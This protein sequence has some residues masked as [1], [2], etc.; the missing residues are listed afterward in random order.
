MV[1]AL[2]GTATCRGQDVALSLSSGSASPG[3]TVTL[4]ISLTA[5]TSLPASLE[6]TLSY[7]TV[8]F[9]SLTI[10]AGPVATGAN[11][12]VTCATSA[13]ISRCIVSGLNDATIP[14]GV[15]ATIS[16]T[17]S[18]STTDTS[19]QVQFMSDM[20]SGTGA[21]T[22][23]I[24]SS[25]GVV[26][27]VPVAALNGFSCTP[28]TVSPSTGSTCT[29]ALTRAPGS[30]GATIDL[31]SSPADVTIPST[32][33][34][35]QGSTS[36][37]F[38]VG[39]RSV[40][41]ATTVTLGASYSS[42]SETFGLTVDPALASLKS[43][44]VS[45]ASIV[46]GQSGTGTVTLASAAPSGGAV[47]SLSSPNAAVS[48]PAS[49]TVPQGSTSA[50]FSVTTGTVTTS[51]SVTLTASYSGVTATFGITVNPVA[52][53][54][55]S[56]SVS[57]STIVSGQSGKGTVTLTSAAPSGGAVVSLS[58]T[59]AAASVPVSLTVPQGA[60]SVT[61]NVTTGTVGTATSITLTAS[62]DS[63]NKTAGITVNP[64]LAALSSLSVS[65]ST[66]VSG[67]PGTGTVTL[68]AAAPSGG[69]VVSLL[70]STKNAAVSVPASVTIAQG[71]TSA[72]FS[73]IAGTVTTSTSVTLSASYSGV[74][75][76]FALTVN[77]VAASLSSL[78][79]SPST[80]VSG[81]PGT[82]TVTLTAAA[83][84]GGAV[85]SLLLSAKNAP[86]SVPASVTIAQG[87]TSATFSVIAG[88]VTTST[89]VTLS[90]SYSG[91]TSTFALTVNPVAA[92]LSSLSVS[93]S[94]IVGGQSGTGTV[95]LTA[96]APAGGAVV[97]LSSP[98]AAA[99]VP[100]TVTV[101]QGSTLV[102]F[103][104]TAGTVTASTSITLTASYSGVAATFGVTVNPGAAVLTSIS[105]S[106]STIV[107]GQSGTGTV[108]ITSAAPSGGAL[109][110]LSSSNSSAAS[111]PASV[112]VA[113]G[114]I[115][116][117]FSVTT[118]IVNAAT[119]VT[120]TATYSGVSRTFG[121]TVNPTPV[122]ADISFVQGNYATPQTP[123]TTVN[124]K[125]LATQEPGD[126]NVIVVG[127]NDSTAVVNTVTDTSGNTYTLALGPTVLKGSLSQSIYYAKN[128]LANAA[129]S[130][131]ITITFSVA[132]AY[133]DIRILEYSGVD[134]KNPV[135]VTAAKSGNSK[136][137]RS[138]SVTT[139]NAKDLLFAANIVGTFT[140]NA[141]T[142]FTNRMITSPDGDLVEDRLVTATGSYNATAPLNESGP[143][144]MQ[145]VALR[146]AQ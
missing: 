111:V 9:S 94:T 40:T 39:A 79:V 133:P 110:S 25:G 7:S 93:P 118:G 112:T 8:D 52:A 59:N 51:T 73:V 5:S 114:A 10:A 64:V 142:G 132:A 95:K 102:T 141:G 1:L 103:S 70:L 120:L 75:S 86:V 56:L 126:L 83:P 122:A 33:T 11:K 3:A 32:V 90:A 140:G 129:G 12:S 100:A 117:T 123:Q 2:I 92:S 144:I 88:T 22:L 104:V 38:S 130:N 57:P 127:W 121:L 48:V 82:G 42:A 58:S 26:T 124:V 107:S 15:V 47:V 134:S 6:W 113:Q 62:Y 99:S 98:S 81:Q 68:T 137:S 139:T 35:P 105:V 69:A 36:T 84:S 91:V 4:N 53:A 14:N 89:S 49:V 146:A 28:I 54:L 23:P 46:S 19:S 61:F 145:M 21:T 115:S 78:S 106:P 17:V 80:M 97:S 85:V 31:S 72:S 138:G 66:M 63:M 119:S 101:P 128:I 60:T 87:A 76:T 135:D 116:A 43:I 65:P 55:S 74:T 27:I 109:V 18:T 44:S 37:T 136:T 77:P 20:A 24:S 67:Q 71:A 96:A 131:I 50:T 13:G 16:L 125:F 41:T 143:W 45:P 29:V 108:T 30:G 34:I